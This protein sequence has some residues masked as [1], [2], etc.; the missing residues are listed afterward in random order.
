MVSLRPRDQHMS[1]VQTLYLAHV[2]R[3]KLALEASYD[4]LDLRVVVGH[5]NLLD[6]LMMYL[7][8]T[9]QEHEPKQEQTRVAHF[10]QSR[11]R[12]LN[13]INTN[14]LA[15]LDGE[16]EQAEDLSDDDDSTDDETEFHHIDSKT[17][18][19]SELSDTDSDDQAEEEFALVRTKSHHS[20]PELFHDCESEPDEIRTKSH[21]SPPELFHDS[22]S[23]PEEGPESPPIA[24]E[25]LARMFTAAMKFQSARASLVSHFEGSLLD[26]Y[27]C[28]IPV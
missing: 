28:P 10:N 9:E 8:T 22:E 13:T 11:Q 1:R 12:Q 16:E 25:S 3:Q 7:A 6:N 17:V 2:A 23:E 15:E 26:G 27:D 19:T 24:E 21:H 4:D 20:P 18:A 14:S 5:A